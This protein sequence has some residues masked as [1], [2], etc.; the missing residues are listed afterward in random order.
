MNGFDRRVELG[1]KGPGRGEGRVFRLGV[2]RL[3]VLPSQA[4]GF[5]F[6]G[7][8]TLPSQTLEFFLLRPGDFAFSGS[9]KA[10]CLRRP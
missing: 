3:G 10:V 5:A 6:T 9:A 4:L 2:F 7:Q 8:G 1:R